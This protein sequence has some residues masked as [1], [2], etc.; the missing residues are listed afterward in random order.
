M[1]PKIN[2][3]VPE[4]PF[5]GPYDHM[6]PK[7]VVDLIHQMKYQNY[8]REQAMARFSVIDEESVKQEV[9]EKIEEIKDEKIVEEIV[10]SLEKI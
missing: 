1:E 9:F 10:Q 5:K 8:L 4:N 7:K 2:V 3:I 6:F